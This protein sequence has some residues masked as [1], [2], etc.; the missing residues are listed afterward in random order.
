MMRQV[1]ENG[2]RDHDIAT[3]ARRMEHDDI[4]HLSDLN[5]AEFIR[6][7]AR[8]DS[9]SEIIEHDDLL[10][11]KGA[12]ST[13]I[14]NVA[15][16]LDRGGCRP[17]D[18]VMGRL[19]SYYTA[20]KTGFSLHI[21]KHDD[22]GM[23]ARCEKENMRRISDAPGMMIGE[24][25][26][27]S[28]LA[29]GVELRQALD[30]AA[31]AEF[32]GVAIES[33]KTLAMPEA[34]GSKIFATPERMIRPYNHLVVGYLRGEPVSCAMAMMS[35]SIAGIYWVGTVPDARGK[36]IAGACTRAV[37]N[38]ALRRGARFAVL[39]ASQFGEPLYREMGFREIT[40]YPWYMYFYTG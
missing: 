33:Y 15:F 17:C 35:H 3:G 29:E 11:T 40:R 1:P 22:D 31:A 37:V 36:G 14:T 32:A 2:A 23:E 4:L 38:E 8:W 25:I 26:P 9:A 13:P 34:V 7:M 30:S 5:L 39:Q 27:D 16:R 12:G 6:E 10:I 20:H 28:P 18:E 24:Q 21:R 19:I